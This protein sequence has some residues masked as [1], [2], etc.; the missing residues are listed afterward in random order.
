[1]KIPTINGIISRRLLLNYRIAP[2]VVRGILPVRFRPKL[3]DGYAICG[4]C[5]IRLEEIRP[6]GLPKFL[7]IHSENSA[8]RIAVEWEDD[9][10]QSHEGVYV[11][12]RD[13]N[14]RLNALAGGRIFPGVHHF[15]RFTV[16]DAKGR[17]SLRVQARDIAEPLVDIEVSETDAFPETSIFGSLDV[18][19]KFFEAGCMGYS[20]R[21][22]SCIMDGLILQVK[23][24]QVTPLIVH[25]IRSAYFDDRALFPQGSIDFDHALLMRDIPHEWHSLPEMTVGK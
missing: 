15:S 11:P 2:E 1:M 17:I 9:A 21:P 4:I 5:L 25:H 6:K 23:Q 8:H 14:S 20:A 19:S 24:W 13:T 16:S 10:G 7:G 22:D 18:S 12:R 3:V